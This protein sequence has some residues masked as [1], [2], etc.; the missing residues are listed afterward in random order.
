MSSNSGAF[1]RISRISLG[2]L[3]AENDHDLRI[4]YVQNPH[5]E[6]AASEESTK[7]Y[8]IGKKGFGKSALLQMLRLSKPKDQVVDLGRDFTLDIH[9]INQSLSSLP[10]PSRALLFRSLWRAAIMLRVYA[11]CGHKWGMMSRTEPQKAFDSVRKQLGD[12]PGAPSFAHTLRL[13]VGKLAASFEGFGLR[14]SME[15]QAATDGFVD[16]LSRTELLHQIHLASTNLQDLIRPQLNYVLIDDLDQDWRNEPI[17]NEYVAALFDTIER[18]SRIPALRFIV[19]L[20]FDI[21][22]G[23]PLGNPDKLVQHVHHLTWTRDT[24]RRIVEQRLERALG[25]PPGRTRKRYVLNRRSGNPT[26]QILEHCFPHPRD[27]IWTFQTIFDRAAEI[28]AETIPQTLIDHAL[29][30]ASRNRVV[31]T[32][33]EWRNAFPWLEPV[34]ARFLEGRTVYPL[35]ELRQL[36]RGASHEAPEADAIIQGL[37]TTGLVGLKYRADGPASFFVAEDPPIFFEKNAF[38]ELHPAARHSLHSSSWRNGPKRT[39]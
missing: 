24:L 11:A 39:A 21:F 34:L 7:S 10:T 36:L 27:A 28:S 25:E 1:S 35:C 13:M 37:L 19:S 20:R 31:W 4:N 32:C 23:L 9:S 30:D 22:R 6:L 18:F 8:F 38:F 3:V 5:F 14:V 12:F 16:R 15:H 29:K 17:Q 26:D 33:S 2:D